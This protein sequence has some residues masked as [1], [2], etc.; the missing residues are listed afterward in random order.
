MESPSAVSRQRAEAIRLHATGWGRPLFRLL[1]PT[2]HKRARLPT[3]TTTPHTSQSPALSPP[4]P[5]APTSP[6]RGELR[7]G[8]ALASRRRKASSA[9]AS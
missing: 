5:A 4:S 9:A 6:A 7:D 1:P 2:H 8:R 3:G